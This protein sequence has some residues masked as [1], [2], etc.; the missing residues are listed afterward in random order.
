MS[1]AAAF[2]V[3]RTAAA[4]LL[5]LFFLHGTI[6]VTSLLLWLTSTVRFVTMAL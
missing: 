6:K 5:C 1:A 4:F 2:S 3:Y